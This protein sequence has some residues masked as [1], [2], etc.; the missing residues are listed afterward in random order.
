MLVK[1]SM[2]DEF[3]LKKCEAEAKR[4]S[5]YKRKTAAF[6]DWQY[7]LKKGEKLPRGR[8][9]HNKTPGKP[10]VMMD[11]FHMFFNRSTQPQFPYQ[12]E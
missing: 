4:K 7:R 8:F 12:P 10:V 2:P 6:Q 9:F 1:Q 11:E 3:D 5:A